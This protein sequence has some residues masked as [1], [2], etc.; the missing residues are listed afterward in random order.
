MGCDEQQ[1]KR[2]SKKLQHNICYFLMARGR[3]RIPAIPKTELPMT[4]S[5][6]FFPIDIVRKG[7]IP[8]AADTIN[9]PLAIAILLSYCRTHTL[10]RSL[11]CII[12]SAYEVSCILI[13]KVPF[14]T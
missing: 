4:I 12:D 14:D 13:F 6:C 2:T 9:S 11:I 10:S 7:S 1:T 5:P 8:D 3:I